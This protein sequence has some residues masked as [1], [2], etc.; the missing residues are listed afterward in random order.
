MNR[1]N[2]LAVV[3]LSCA[4]IAS[5]PCA[6]GCERRA[7]TSTPTT[8]SRTDVESAERLY[9]GGQFGPAVQVL[10]R[11][12]ARDP[13]DLDARRR[14]G[15]AYV[16]QGQVD[17]AIRQYSAVVDGSPLD[18]VTLYRLALLK[19]QAGAFN[20]AEVLLARA[21]ERRSDSRVYLE[22]LART[23]ARA[24]KHGGA[25]AVWERLLGRS[26]VTGPRRVGILIECGQSYLALKRPDDARRLFAEAERLDPKNVTVQR[27]SRRVP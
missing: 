18:D 14:L 7:A 6:A 25:V 3:V 11:V 1:N 15:L 10:E 4:I 20:E 12:I 22:E 26:S 19:R 27:M 24:G 16:A 21:V 2:S 5:L 23:R 13:S 17:K 8:T 9:E